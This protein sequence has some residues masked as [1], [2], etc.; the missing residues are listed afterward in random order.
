FVMTGINCEYLALM[1]IQV[2]TPRS[3]SLATTH[4]EIDIFRLKKDE[5][6]VGFLLG[7]KSAG[8]NVLAEK[9]QRLVEGCLFALD[10][11][12]NNAHLSS[13]IDNEEFKDAKFIIQLGEIPKI[14]PTDCQHVFKIISE[15]PKFLLQSPFKKR[16][17][18]KELQK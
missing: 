4:P 16:S 11:Q 8:E 6:L 1:D 12:Y 5:R 7:Q 9:E 14:L 17:L 18:W 2:W 10:L 13:L 3:I 15:S